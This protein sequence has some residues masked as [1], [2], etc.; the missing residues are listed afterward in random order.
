MEYVACFA[1]VKMVFEI[2]LDNIF[3]ILLKNKTGMDMDSTRSLV[4]LIN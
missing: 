4:K 2:R 3:G 1:G